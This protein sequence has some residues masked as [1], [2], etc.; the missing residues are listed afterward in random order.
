MKNDF[1]SQKK[2]PRKSFYVNI[3]IVFYN[4]VDYFM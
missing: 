1:R 3:I 4:Y 2:Q